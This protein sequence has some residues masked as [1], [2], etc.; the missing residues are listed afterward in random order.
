VSAPRLLLVF[1]ALTAGGRCAR[2]AQALEHGALGIEPAIEWRRIEALQG[3]VED[4]LWAN[5]VLFCTTEN[6]GYMS[7]GLKHFFDR[8]FYPA[9]GRVQGL[10]YAI[11]IS[12]GNDGSGAVRAIQRIAAG[13][14]LKEVQPPLIVRQDEDL[15]AACRRAAELGATMAAGLA[16]G[17]Y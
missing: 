8:S 17:L 6:F 11:V 7:G 15:D 5:G 3:G 2:L 1:H 16:F 9:Q 4:L 12:A 10:P 14:P 13:F